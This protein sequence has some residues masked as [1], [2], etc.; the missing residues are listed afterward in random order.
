MWLLKVLIE[1]LENNQIF[2]ANTELINLL[3]VC[4]IIEMND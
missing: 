4:L 2:I 1:E 3:N